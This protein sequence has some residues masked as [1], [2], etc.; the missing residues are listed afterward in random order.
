VSLIGVHPMDVRLMRASH[1]RVSHRCASHRRATHGRASHDMSL[2]GV[3][4][5]GD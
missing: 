3:Y 4:V 1:R 5:E 2:I